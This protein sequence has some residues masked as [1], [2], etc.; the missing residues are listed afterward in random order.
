MIAKAENTKIEGPVISLEDI[1]VEKG[2]K[3]LVNNRQ[4]GNS[5]GY[6]SVSVDNNVDDYLRKLARK[7][8]FKPYDIPEKTEYELVA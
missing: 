2:L 4:Y 6:G 8:V 5:I 3:D 7:A 1:A